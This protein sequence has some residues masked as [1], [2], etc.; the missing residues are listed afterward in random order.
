M[1]FGSLLHCTPRSGRPVKCHPGIE[2]NIFGRSRSSLHLRHDVNT[3]SWFNKN[4]SAG[5][6]SK[7]HFHRPSTSIDIEYLAG[8]FA[9]EVAQ[10]HSHFRRPTVAYRGNLPRLLSYNIFIPA[11]F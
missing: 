1:F 6:Y 4:I 10:D 5:D 8:A 9:V 11:T 7:C 3:L 2:I